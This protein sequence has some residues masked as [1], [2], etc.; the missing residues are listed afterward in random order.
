[1]KTFMN[2]FPRC[3][4]DASGTYF[5]CVHTCIILKLKLYVRLLNTGGH[6]SSCTC[7]RAYQTRGNRQ[8][9]IRQ[10]W[11]IPGISGYI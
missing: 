7:C 6:T 2:T 4:N 9:E 3:Y 1:M 8:L 11:S 5:S 10:G